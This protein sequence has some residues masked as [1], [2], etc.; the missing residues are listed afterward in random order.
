M[1]AVRMAAI[2]AELEEIG[3]S[4]D[5]ISALELIYAAIEVRRTFLD[6]STPECRTPKQQAEPRL[7]PSDTAA[8]ATPCN[9]GQAV[10]EKTAYLCGIR[11]P[12]QSP[13]ITYYHS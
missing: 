5:L 11:N 9:R 13:A 8:D 12:V 1:Q 7:T 6:N 3:C 10:E 2:C 4:G